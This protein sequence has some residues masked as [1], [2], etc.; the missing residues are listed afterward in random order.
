MITRSAILA[1]LLFVGASGIAAEQT[2]APVSRER[3]LGAADHI[4]TFDI[5]SDRV[6]TIVDAPAVANT[7]WRFFV[8]A[9]NADASLT[10]R[11]TNA[12]DGPV[13]ARIPLDSLKHGTWSPYL[14]ARSVFFEAADAADVAVEMIGFRETSVGTQTP[15]GKL[16]LEPVSSLQLGLELRQLIGAVGHL[17]VIEGQ[18]GG[19]GET[20]FTYCTAFLIAPDRA[21]TAEHCVARGLDDRFAQITFG[22][23]DEDQP[24]GFGRHDVSVVVKSRAHDIAILAI[25]PPREGQTVFQLAPVEPEPDAEVMVLQH[26]GGEPLSVSSDSKCLVSDT[27]YGGP[28]F[29]ADNAL[30]KL[31]GIRFGHGCDTTKSSSGAPVLDRNTFA[32]VGMHQR[33]YAPGGVQDNLALRLG[34]IKTF[35]DSEMAAI[36]Y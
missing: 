9:R 8:R 4:Q 25:D 13:I 32:V 27:L 30:T 21:L 12:A 36:E 24:L 28:S 2:V 22:Y 19:R 3:V 15:V 6:E 17:A 1:A 5:G 11:D 26:F 33:G 18:L 16:N 23:V 14:T 7:P 35:V 31:P 34:E 10:L 29:L 20:Y